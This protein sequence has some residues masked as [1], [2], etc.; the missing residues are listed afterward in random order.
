MVACHS[1]RLS[2]LEYLPKYYEELGCDIAE[3][4]G[5]IP[6]S[7]VVY[8]IF[9]SVSF[10]ASSKIPSK[11]ASPKWFPCESKTSRWLAFP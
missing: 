10:L 11:D 1:K 9:L 6:C 2:M 4:M 5:G 7:P 3:A 8:R